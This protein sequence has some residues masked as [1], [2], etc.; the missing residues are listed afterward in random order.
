MLARLAISLS[1]VTACGSSTP[2]GSDGGAEALDSG[3]EP[4]ARDVVD[5]PD[6]EDAAVPSCDSTIRWTAL[7]DLPVGRD[8]HATAITAS[9]YLYAIG[10]W[11]GGDVLADVWFAKIETDGTTG[12]WTAGPPIPDGG[13]SGAAVGAIGDTL[14]VAGGRTQGFGYP[15]TNATWI[16]HT[17]ADGTFDAWSPGPDLPMP[18]F[19]VQIGVHGRAL[20]I[21]GGLDGSNNIVTVARATLGEDG[22]LS[23][24]A[25]QTPLPERRSHHAVVVHDDA[26][27]V[28]GGLVGDPAAS[29]REPMEPIRAHPSTPTRLSARGRR[30]AR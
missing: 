8:H 4:D 12:A 11:G 19:H 15:F 2:P 30:P 14:V 25:M 20:F 28:V 24:W 27:Y 7:D 6:A 5:A 26:L 1:M 23:D 3:N 18:A 17:A 9:G 16:A 22:E 13:A 10:G 29:P 21:A